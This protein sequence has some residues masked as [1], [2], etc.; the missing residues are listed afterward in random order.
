MCIGFWFALVFAQIHFDTH[1][2]VFSV[3]SVA[4]V[5]V[6]FY[7]CVAVY[8]MFKRVCFLDMIFPCNGMSGLETCCVEFVDVKFIHRH[9]QRGA[10]TC[11]FIHK[12]KVVSIGSFIHWLDCLV[13]ASSIF[14]LK[15]TQFFLHLNFHVNNLFC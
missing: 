5:V 3:S 4:A 14:E 2:T 1:C 13:N 8:L 7:C 11:V 15:Y 6:L 12:L 9:F 10:I